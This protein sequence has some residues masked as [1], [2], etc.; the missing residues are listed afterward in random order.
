[1]RLKG[2]QQTSRAMN[3]RLILN[4][5]RRDGAISRAGIAAHTG[6]SAAAVTFVV[7][8]LIEEGLVIEGE[9]SRGTTGR[10]PIPVD[11]NYGGRLTIGFK[12]NSRSLDAVLC[13]LSTSPLRSLSEPIQDTHPETVVKHAVEMVRL[14]VPDAQ[15]RQKKLI[16]VGLALPGTYDIETGI[17]TFLS[18]FGWRD[19]PI[20]PMLAAQL[21]VPVWVDNEVKAYALAQY[22]FGRGRKHGTLMALALGVGIGSAFMNNGAI[23]R[24]TV[25]A[26]GE[27]GH[28]L[29]S[30]GGR[31]CDCGRRGCLQAYFSEVALDADWT[32]H[33]ALCPDALPDLAAAAEAGDSQALDLLHRAGEGIGTMLATV[34]DAVDPDIILLCGEA[35]RFGDFLIGPMKATVYDRTF[36]SKPEFVVEWQPNSW[37]RAA[38][39]LAVQRFFDF[40]SR[41]TLFELGTTPLPRG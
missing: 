21:D 6:L 28:S 30:P 38:A 22:L 8:D 31:L 32:E 20:G 27:I 26:A 4:L 17:C 29:H 14:L 36:L 33:V 41:T 25:G 1:M 9:A 12:L 16:G 40:E 35:L 5:M 10:R 19:V 23:H 2:D 37:T 34:V 15:E 18:R 13:D 39:A 3:R 24:G 11:I 7:A